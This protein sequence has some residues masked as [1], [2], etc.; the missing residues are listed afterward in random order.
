[1]TIVI[2]TKSNLEFSHEIVLWIH[3][4]PAIVL[5]YTSFERIVKTCC[6]VPFSFLFATLQERKSYEKITLFEIV[7]CNGN[8]TSKYLSK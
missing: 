2:I 1:M 4:A 3:F 8:I 7:K 6:A 5:L